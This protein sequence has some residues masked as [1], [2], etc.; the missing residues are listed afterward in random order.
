[1]LVSLVLAAVAELKTY[2][3]VESA[4]IHIT[5]FCSYVQIASKDIF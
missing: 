2:D 3:V 5:N 1:M 4:E